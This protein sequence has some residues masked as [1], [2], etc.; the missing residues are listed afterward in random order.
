MISRSPPC[1]LTRLRV[2]P[3]TPARKSAALTSGS[4]SGRMIAVMSFMHEPRQGE[5]AGEL[6]DESDAA[7]L[8]GGVAAPASR[9]DAAALNTTGTTRWPAGVRATPG[10]EL[11]ARCPG[12]PA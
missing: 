1:P 6:G 7:G 8:P 3:V 5:P 11:S 2:I 10:V 9:T 12:D 4:R